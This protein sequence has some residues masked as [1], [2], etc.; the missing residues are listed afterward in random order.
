[1]ARHGW[2]GLGRRQ[3][4]IDTAPRAA[5]LDAYVRTAP[6]PQNALD[7]FAGEW[8]SK[9]PPPYDGLQAGQAFLFDDVRLRWAME[10]MGGVAG[11]RVLELGPL[12]GGHTYMLDRAGATDV[13][14]V[15]ANTRAYLKCLIAKE[16]L[17]V[18]AARFVCG[19]F[20]AFLRET[21]DRVDLVV[22]SG[23]LYHMIDPVELITQIAAV[24]DAVYLWTHYYDEAILRRRPELA[25]RLVPP[26]P[27]ESGGFRHHLYRNDYRT[28][29]DSAA[30]CGG[31]RP[32]SNWLPREHILG[33]LQ[34][35]GLG[36][37]EINY[38]QTDHEN[39][40]AFSV[41][42]RR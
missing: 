10:R 39:G 1:M 9:L 4:A 13:L 38:E 5:A 19:D 2:F 17:G 29:L 22:A 25:Y 21:R 16:L 27:S 11:K 12:E 35:V 18:P 34:H 28:A 41:L 23:V 6:D 20:S 24:T 37:I 33:A 30:F 15:E 26:Q 40:P 36:T 14:A 8:S 32:Y 7:L 3:A 31:S 42:A